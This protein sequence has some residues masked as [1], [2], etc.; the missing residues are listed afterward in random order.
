MF[1]PMHT[2]PESR[3]SWGGSPEARREVTN[4]IGG[5]EKLKSCLGK[6]RKVSISSECCL[7]A[8]LQP[9]GQK[10]TH[11]SAVLGSRVELCSHQAGDPCEHRA[12]LSKGIAPGLG[13][14]GCRQARAAGTSWRV[15]LCHLW[16]IRK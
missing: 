6:R 4:G 3:G 7:C 14:A 11:G 5:F 2:K 12:A 13:H 15:N 9:E 10:G 1:N 8:P 16:V